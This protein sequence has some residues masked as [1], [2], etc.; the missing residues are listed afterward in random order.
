MSEGQRASQ[1]HAQA[2]PSPR[3]WKIQ[4]LTRR[5]LE[6]SKSHHASASC[7]RARA[8]VLCSLCMASP[9]PSS[10]RNCTWLLTPNPRNLQGIFHRRFSANRVIRFH[11]DSVWNN[12]RPF[13]GRQRLEWLGQPFWSYRVHKVQSNLIA[14]LIIL[15]PWIMTNSRLIYLIIWFWSLLLDR[16]WLD[17]ISTVQEKDIKKK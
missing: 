13:S 2:S 14:I 12:Q 1:P 16:W 17:H 3:T 5:P 6:P 11:R 8:V 10:T 7:L 15:G 9:S 4:P